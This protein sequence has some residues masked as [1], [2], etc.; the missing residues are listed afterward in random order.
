MAEQTRF[1]DLVS[2]SAGSSLS[3]CYQCGK[4]SAGCPVAYAMDVLPHRIIRAVLFNR[5]EMVLSSRTVWICAG[6]E[7]CTTRCPNEIDIAR[8]MDAVRQ[9]HRETGREAA[10]HNAPYL[11]EAFMTSIR[12]RGRVHELSMIGRYSF[13]S[14]DFKEKI[15]SGAWKNDIKLALKM[16]VRGKLKLIPKRCKG[17]PDVRRLFMLSRE[18]TKL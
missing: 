18:H 8:V 2:A 7:T 1:R 10:V 9:V 11:H 4:C 14:G 5:K 15:A 13:R 3:G 12:Q 6:C 17:V 16:L